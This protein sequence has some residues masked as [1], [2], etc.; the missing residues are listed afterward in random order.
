MA[1]VDGLLAGRA[2]RCRVASLNAYGASDYS[3]IA[4]IPTQP[5]VPDPPSAPTLSS[6]PR[7][8]SLTLSW[9]LPAIVHGAAVT[10][11]MFARF[12]HI[13]FGTTFV[14]VQ[15]KESNGSWTQRC[16]V[17]A[18]EATIGELT[19]GRTYHFRVVVVNAAGVSRTCVAPKQSLM[20]TEKPS[21]G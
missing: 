19:P 8:T 12:F 7:P 5:D 6:K 9:R 3:Q 11:S 20:P 10:Q 21:V 13:A 1:T 14:S 15:Q 17:A 18:T 16:E 4:I 2:Y